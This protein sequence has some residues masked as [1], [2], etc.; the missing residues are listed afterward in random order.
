MHRPRVLSISPR[1]YE[2][3]IWR[4]GQV[5]F[6][7]LIRS[8]DDVDLVAP[9]PVLRGEGLF[10][11]QARRV[12]KLASVELSFKP[13][14]K[15]VTLERDYELFAYHA[16]QP[17][18]LALLDAIPD[19]RRRCQKAVCFVDEFWIEDLKDADWLET[20]AAFD[21]VAVMFYNTVEPLQKAVG[22]PCT[23]VPAAVDTLRFFP[24]LVPPARG[25]DVY[26]MGRRSDESHRV[27]LSH[28]SA[29]NWTYL[30]DTI[31]PVR[32]RDELQDHRQQL[33]ELIK[34][35][36]YFIANKAKVDSPSHRGTQEEIGF[37]SFE[38]AAGGAILVG[39]TPQ[40][41]SLQLLFDWPD[42]HIHVPFGSTEIVDVIRALDADPERVQGIRRNNVVN[43]LLRH[44]WA[45]R[46]Q[47]VLAE[48]DLAPSP[49][50]LARIDK[51]QHL[52]RSISHEGW[53]GSATSEQR[54]L[55]QSV[56]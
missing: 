32:V 29:H 3:A 52:A 43:S 39:H 9:E 19:W 53:P 38:G 35:T 15:P 5:E 33:A 10:A 2:K 20:L 13:R 36:R 22:V 54:H 11:R 6:E 51:L 23:W 34:R 47:T 40:A 1:R 55:S 45:Y 27:L 16:S 46:W 18:D 56:G 28:A 37:R 17:T 31:D 41:K 44:D 49:R 12:A 24:G 42:A 30:F 50:L 7:D 25:I 8:I 21:H 26:A 4:C 14:L 48:L